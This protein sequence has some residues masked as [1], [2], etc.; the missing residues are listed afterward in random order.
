MLEQSFLKPL[1]LVRSG[2]ELTS[3]E[4]TPALKVMIGFW[5][6][7]EEVFGKTSLVDGAFK[8]GYLLKSHSFM[9]DTESRN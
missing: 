5:D 8:I 9:W 3:T 7:T 1:I 6:I 4:H 2:E